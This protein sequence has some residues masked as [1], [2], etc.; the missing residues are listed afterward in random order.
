MI[1]CATLLAPLVARAEHGVVI[2]SKGTVT[3]APKG[4]KAS[5]AAVGM[6]LPEG[7]TITTNA[8]GYVTILLASGAVHRLVPN[9]TIIITTDEPVQGSEGIVRG[10]SVAL[11]EMIHRDETQDIHAMVKAAPKPF[12]LTPAHQKRMDEDLTKV[13]AMNIDSASGRTF[14]KAQVYYKYRQYQKALD[15]LL[16]V[17]AAEARPGTALSNLIALCYD[18]LGNADKAKQ[19][20]R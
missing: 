12:E 13:D 2:E 16:E 18:K 8:D 6:D 17:Y 9:K 10:I 1:A 5:G 15:L 7:T 11:N 20:R 14:L 3:V 4:K 19:Y